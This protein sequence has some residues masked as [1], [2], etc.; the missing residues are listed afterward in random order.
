MRYLEMARRVDVAHAAG[1]GRQLAAEVELANARA[2]AASD[3]VRL[4]VAQLSDYLGPEPDFGTGAEVSPAEA[5]D[6]ARAMLGLARRLP[7]AYRAQ[8][9][10]VA[11]LAHEIGL[12]S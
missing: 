2:A 7:D 8:L 5:A 3:E 12:R 4:A 11:G 9:P 10:P 1:A 6:Q